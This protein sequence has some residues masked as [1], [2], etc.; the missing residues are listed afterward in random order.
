MNNNNIDYV[1]TLSVLES[2]NPINQDEENALSIARM[3]C[4]KEIPVE[5][6][7]ETGHMDEDMNGYEYI[8]PI[9][10]V[11][12][13]EENEFVGRCDCGQMIT[14]PNFED[15]FGSFSKSHAWNPK[16]EEW[17]KKGKKERTD[18]WK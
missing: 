9:C 14:I 12:L 11:L 2:I 18:V 1:E 13:L 16:K 3:L 10:E 4:R 7:V 6:K 8:C 15:W 5:A 17:V